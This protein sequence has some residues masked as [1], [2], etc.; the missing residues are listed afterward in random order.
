M[1][2][3]NKLKPHLQQLNQ[4]IRNRQN[5]EGAVSDTLFGLLKNTNQRQIIVDN[6]LWTYLNT[7]HSGID[8]TQDITNLR[9]M[10]PTTQANGQANTVVTINNTTNSNQIQQIIVQIHSWIANLETRLAQE[11]IN[12]NNQ[13]KPQQ[14]TYRNTY[15]A[16]LET[17]LNQHKTNLSILEKI[18]PL[19]QFVDNYSWLTQLRQTECTNIQN[20]VWQY[21]L[22][23]ILPNNTINYSGWIANNINLDTVFLQQNQNPII[24]YAICDSNTWVELQ[25]KNWGLEAT[26]DWWEKVVIKWLSIIN[27][28]QLSINNIT[29]YPIKDIKFPITVPVAI[30]WRIQETTTGANVDHYKW[31]DLIINAPTMLQ[32]DREQCYD[33]YNNNWSINN[34]IQSEYNNKHEWRENE[35]IRDVLRSNGNETE[36]NKIHENQTLR[37]EFMHR[38]RA[39]N[40][41]QFPMLNLQNLQTEF[42][43]N[44][45]VESRK[46]P[47]E[48][49]VWTNEFTD[50]IRNNIAKN[51]KDFL[52]KQVKD[53]I[54]SS[55]AQPARN[56]VLNMF[57][58]FQTNMENTLWDDPNVR[59]NF[60]WN[61]FN[62]NLPRINRRRAN[63]MRFLVWKSENLWNQN[64]KLTDKK[65]NY[66][67]SLSCETMDK[68][69]ANIEV[70]GKKI[71]AFAWKNINEL[72]RSIIQSWRIESHKLAA[73]IAFW[74]IKTLIKMIK[75]NNMNI[76]VRN[77]NGNLFE[78]R[79]DNDKLSIKEVD[80]TWHTI[81][82]IFDEEHF[83]KLKDF[84]T[85]NIALWQ[86]SWDFHR[87]M[88]Y[89][90]RD[91]RRATQYTRVNRLMKYDPRGTRWLR[92]IRKIW[93]WKKK[94]RLDFDFPSTAVT[95][96]DKTANISFEKGKFTVSIWD[97]I[98]TSRNIWRILKKNRE[99]DGMQMEIISTINSKFV[100]MLRINS[101]VANT[102]FWVYDRSLRRLYILDS[103]WWLNYIDNPNTN[104][105]SWITRWLWYWR[106]STSNMP[107][108]MTPVTSESEIAQF[109]QNPLLGGRMVKSMMRRLWGI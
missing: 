74:S 45:T 77:W 35:V 1:A 84:N 32:A 88:H 96:W 5:L 19:Q 46:V 9:W 28:N 91:Y 33:N 103:N 80:D 3:D 92:R 75:A 106:I 42:R 7:I 107:N 67:I 60:Q 83:S 109:W 8:V 21:N 82:K 90:N 100:E 101:R 99:F 62:I 30:R 44:M 72:M 95:V 18:L 38:L 78:T 34:R 29:I 47:Q 68:L 22:T 39:N 55:T 17:E 61:L 57:T 105:I 23:N 85:L 15:I 97:K 76:N 87:I 64:F 59:N 41:I 36:V 16:P 69:V 73:H 94:N 50:Y 58:D 53:N 40:N 66:S 98:Y 4:Q 102:N 13:P 81:N 14:Q 20:V 25:S 89:Y 12:L 10:L 79:I 71:P 27:N 108:S 6:E 2:I 37:D 24:N 93:N 104:P 26:L 54:N 49:L 70:N 56:E 86:L 11:K 65:Y 31:F 48:Y 63:Y 52:K 43:T 51:V